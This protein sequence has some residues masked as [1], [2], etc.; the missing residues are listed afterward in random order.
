MDY[1]N[2]SLPI[3][4]R[5]RDLL[6][7]MTEAEKIG[8]L[9]QPFGW[10]SYIK[11]A[12]GTVILTEEFKLLAASGGVGSLYGTL[13]ADPWT[14]VTLENGLSPEDGAAAVNMIQQYAIQE[15][16]LG[17][18]ILFGEECSH[19]HMAI[20]ATVFPVP[21]N[22]GSTWNPELYQEMCRAVAAE[23]RAQG[24]AA[25][26]SPVLDITRDPRWGRTEETFG[27]DP[28]LTGELAVAAMKGLQGESL[29][30][31]DS[32]MATLKHFAGYGASEGGRNGAPAH[33]GLRE[34]HEVDL[35]PFRKA[36]EAGACSIMP[37]Y[38][39]IDGVPCTSNRYLL[40]EVLRGEWGFDGF[41]IT[42]CGAIDMLENGHNTAATGEE[43]AAAAVQAGVD[44]EMSGGM[45]RKHL[46]EALNQGIVSTEELDL[47]VSRV[48]AMKFRLGLFERPF[49]DPKRAKEVIGKT[50]HKNLARR[51]AEESIILLKNEGGTLPLSANTGTVAVIGPNA[52]APYNQLGDYTS[53]QPE[54]K[55]VTVLEGIRNSIGTERKRVMY[56]PGSRIREDSREGF[57]LALETAAAADV[58]VLVLGGSSA[59]DFGGGAIDLRTGAS[60]VTDHVWSDMECGEGIDR[61][62]LH[63]LGAQTELFREIRKLGKPL[64]VVYINGRPVTEPEIDQ[65]ADAILEA[66]YPGQEG[67][68]AVAAILFGEVNPSGRLPLTLPKDVGQLPLNYHSRRTRGKRYLEG[69]LSPQYPFGFGLS[70]TQFEYSSLRIEP[71]VIGPDEEALVYITVTNSG[72]VPGMEV[73]QLYL[74]DLA[75]SVTR[76]E[77][78]LRGF[79]KVHL[80]PGESRE[81]TFPLNREHLELVGL[82]LR[83][84]VEDGEFV[85]SV[86]SHSAKTISGR[87]A[88]RTKEVQ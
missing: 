56:A 20:G 5:V 11:Q 82:D 44:M 86:G 25:T 10:K 45:F 40:E 63:L 66:W 54:G 65:Q 36:V 34:L 9:I 6:D 42:D 19:G 30:S 7:R 46:A 67:G 48:L 39:E 87:L 49:A 58:T 26:Y 18:P 55:V 4:N 76:P 81:L 83:R 59:R 85:V 13:R 14:E 23:T 53:P 38:N 73:A 35:Y 84:V 74:T 16:R 75:A 12:D 64:V 8:Q 27:E 60:L 70:Y 68:N 1:K 3:A 33:I 41:V 29:D 57:A 28:Y 31:P 79:R 37:A 2:A 43:A 62:S 51:V 17:I 78:S 72:R 47:A 15:S 22:V 32:I 52:D 80:Q 61:S 21:L 77:K 50:E 71:E 88:V 24:G 69:D